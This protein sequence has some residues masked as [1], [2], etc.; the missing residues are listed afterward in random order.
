MIDSRITINNVKHSDIQEVSSEVKEFRITNKHGNYVELLNYGAIV[1][2][3]V[4]KD[5]QGH[6]D[7]VVLGYTALD[8]YV[9]DSNY[10][11]ATIGPFANRIAWSQFYIED[12]EYQLEKNNGLHNNHSGATGFHKKIFDADIKGSS[13]LFNLTRNDGEG[14]FP[15]E[16]KVTVIYSWTNEN[17]LKIVYCAETE[18]PTP[19][20]L[21]NHTYFNLSGCKETIHNHKLSISADDILEIT[22]DFIP[23]GKIVP[24]NEIKFNN[25]IL[26][27]VMKSGGLNNYYIFSGIKKCVLEHE[28]SGRFLEVYTDYPGVQL[29]TGDYIIGNTI[30]NHNKYYGAFDGLCLECQFFPDSP[31]HFNFPNTILKP[32]EKYHRK[33]IYKFGVK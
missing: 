29:Y 6:S 23:T 32:G 15:G 26:K 4:I 2:A 7:N 22:E 16:L 21:T 30:S 20:N 25:G 1:K 27:D 10:I 28:D 18:K 31:N 33:I 19:L 24:A 13:V 11:G 12:K 9:N 17:E 8:G 3:I 14:G 5:K